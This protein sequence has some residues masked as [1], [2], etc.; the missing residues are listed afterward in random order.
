MTAGR[1]SATPK[2]TRRSTRRSATPRTAPAWAPT[3]C[4]RRARATS[5]SW[6]TT[7]SGSAGSPSRRRQGGAGGSCV[8]GP[9]PAGDWPTRWAAVRRARQ[10]TLD[11]RRVGHCPPGRARVDA[12]TDGLTGL[13]NQ[14]YF[15]QRLGEEVARLRRSVT[16]WLCSSAT[17]T[18]SRATTIASVTPPAIAPCG[19]SPASSCAPAARSTSRRGTVARSSR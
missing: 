16:R 5:S 8:C 14:R 18:I 10:G 13:Y 17:S 1:S 4:W 15:K 6:T 3:S 12:V 11:D 7:A 19:P 2:R 9:H